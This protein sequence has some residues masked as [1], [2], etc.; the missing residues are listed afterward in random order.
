MADNH[1]QAK[2][3]PYFS[4]VRSDIKVY[5]NGTCI[6]DKIEQDGSLMVI[7]NLFSQIFGQE[8]LYAVT[9]MINRVKKTERKNTTV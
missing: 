6:L 9:G 4:K 8:I 1:S 7:S 2:F 5:T 3:S